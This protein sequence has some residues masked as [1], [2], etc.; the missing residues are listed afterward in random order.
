[1]RA[2]GCLTLGLALVSSAAASA[3]T[4]IS[5]HITHEPVE[6]IVSHG[7]DG[8]VITRRPIATGPAAAVVPPTIA[9]PTIAQPS[10]APATVGTVTTYGAP[11]MQTI[12]S[13]PASVDEVTTGQAVRRAAVQPARSAARTTRQAGTRRSNAPVVARTDRT[14]RHAAVQ[15]VVLSPAE[16]RLVYSTIVREQVA[17]AV[18]QQVVSTSVPAWSWGSSWSWGPPVVAQTEQV[19]V[20]APAAP[21]VYRVGARLP[22][23]VPLYG[24]PQTVALR[25]PA[26]R[27]YS[28]AHVGG[29]VYLVDPATS[30]IVADLAE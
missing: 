3:Q 4:V 17:P 14:V 25:V 20:V 9:Q 7:P 16:R 21:A 11:A 13:A 30:I 10:W 8:T 28:Y 19:A 12:E 6:T 2:V 26:T 24:I 27:P 15:P 5:R 23:T 29:R 22:E 1:M 18:T